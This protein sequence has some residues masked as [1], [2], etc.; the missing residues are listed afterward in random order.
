LSHNENLFPPQGAK[1]AEKP[2]AAN[3][4]CDYL[5][6][7]QSNGGFDFD[8]STAQKEWKATI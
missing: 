7:S 6:V 2:H 5:Y 8:A 4:K 3:L 1:R